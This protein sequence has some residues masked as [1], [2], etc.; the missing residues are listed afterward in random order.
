[1]TD[2]K[3][4]V[5]FATKRNARRHPAPTYL[6]FRGIC[7]SDTIV[8]DRG[9]FSDQTVMSSVPTTSVQSQGTSKHAR[10][11]EMSSN[12]SWWWARFSLVGCMH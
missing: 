11:K 4:F 12:G 2:A 9:G 6:P 10:Q 5:A 1:M 8:F 7:E 3:F